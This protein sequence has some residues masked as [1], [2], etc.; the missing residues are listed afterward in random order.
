MESKEGSQKP[1][2]KPVVETPSTRTEEKRNKGFEKWLESFKARIHQSITNPHPSSTLEED[3]EAKD[4]ESELSTV[5]VRAESKDDLGLIFDEEEEPFGR[6]TMDDDLDPSFM[7]KT[8]TW[9]MIL[10][11]SLMRKT[12]TWTMILVQSLMR[13]KNQRLSRPREANELDAE[14]GGLM[15]NKKSVFGFVQ[16]RSTKKIQAM[17]V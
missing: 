11:P 2:S 13:R 10:V 17:V 14:R 5:Y 12:I 15:L 9:T 6:W 4:I 8:I 16:E 7:R 1:Q 3:Q